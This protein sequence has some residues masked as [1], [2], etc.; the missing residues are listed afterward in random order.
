[1]DIFLSAGEG[2]L[3]FVAIFGGA[4]SALF[5]AYAGLQ[6]ITAAGDPQRMA[7]ARNGL[8]GVLVGMIMVGS[9]VLVPGVLSRTIIEPAGGGRVDA[10]Y[11]E[12]GCDSILMRQLVLQRQARGPSQMDRVIDLIQG[13]YPSCT[14]D[15]WDLRVLPRG[16]TDSGAIANECTGS[17]ALQSDISAVRMEGLQVPRGLLVAVNDGGIVVW[18]FPDV[19][20]RDLE[21]NILVL[22]TPSHAP[23]GAVHCWVYFSRY[24]VWKSR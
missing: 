10:G 22:W 18:K 21:D 6:W 5:V 19:S 24:G 9:A 17:G 13:R 15:Q 14:L 1:M 12:L 16:H 2:I 3:R 7:Q 20:T 23:S 4:L 11:S 8:I